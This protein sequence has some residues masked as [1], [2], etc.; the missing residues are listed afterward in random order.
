M[1]RA[2][3]AFGN[4]S[5]C[6]L[7]LIALFAPIH[8]ATETPRASKGLD[9]PDAP[10]H[11]IAPE[12]PNSHMIHFHPEHGTLG[13]AIT[14]SILLVEEMLHRKFTST[15]TTAPNV[16]FDGKVRLVGRRKPMKSPPGFDRRLQPANDL[17]INRTYFSA[18]RTK[19]HGPRPLCS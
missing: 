2:S 18:G 11:T 5:L 10:P 19:C 15:A 6:A 7:A 8:L 12:N 16:K 3:L 9:N 17:P 14:K 1:D 13:P 4:V